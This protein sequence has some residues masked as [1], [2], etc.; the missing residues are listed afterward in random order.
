LDHLVEL[1]PVLVFSMTDVGEREG[2]A[3]DHIYDVV[4]AFANYV[5]KY[6]DILLQTTNEQGA[7]LMQQ[8]LNL[9]ASFLSQNFKPDNISGAKI[10]SCVLEGSR[11]K[12]DTFIPGIY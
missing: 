7:S 3:K 5:F 6:N 8:L 10:I 9:C 2:Y 4:S 12:I 1:F 11:G